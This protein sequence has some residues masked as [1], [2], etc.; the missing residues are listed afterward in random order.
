MP[1]AP[2]PFSDT[3]KLRTVFFLQPVAL[4]AWLPQIPQIQAQLGLSPLDLAWSLMGM[5]TGLLLFLAVGGKLAEKT[6]PR[7]FM[8]VGHLAYLALMSAP[9]W[10]MSGPVLFVTLA[11]AGATMAVAELALNVNANAMEQ[12]GGRLIMSGCHGFW[13]LGIL[14]GSLVG[15]LMAG[16]AV[17]PQWVV[18]SV[19]AITCGPIALTIAALRDLP[20]PP[21]PPAQDTADTSWTLPAALVGICLFAFGI[22]LTEGAMADWAA[23][24]LRD[25][26]AAG[27]GLAGLGYT[28]FALMVALGRFTGDALRRKVAL[29]T[30]A[31][32]YC[33]VALAGAVLIALA[34]SA[35]LAFAGFVLLGFG[36]ST[37]FP[38]AVSAVGNLKGRSPAR[39]V[40]VL[41]QISLSGFLVG[42]LAIGT[43]AELQ[44]IRLGMA[45]LIPA[46]LLSLV[47]ARRLPA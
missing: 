44:G 46:L 20:P 22:A 33:L 8:L 31:G 43:L 21:P 25:V 1:T 16:A 27:P 19:A 2:L 26:F 36:V 24:Y 14:S 38:L 28:A 5:P 13:S 34:G 32:L 35:N 6:N 29:R 9:G 40:A 4:G 39:D 3:N 10:S 47:L 15:A 42:P 17:P 37:G 45:A 41:T 11:A 12:R 30:A 18:L 23:I 7:L